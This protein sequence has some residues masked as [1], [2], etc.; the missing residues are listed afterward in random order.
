MTPHR[1]GAASSILVLIDVQERLLGAF[2]EATRDRL[3]PRLGLLLTAARELSIPTVVTEQYPQGLG[4]TLAELRE[5]AGPDVPTLAKTTFSCFGDPAFVPALANARRMPLPATSLEALAEAGTSLILCGI[6]THVCVLQTALDAL[7]AGF[8]RVIVPADAVAA[9][10][11][12]D[13]AVAL[14]LMD[15]EGAWITTAESLVFMLLEDARHPAF[16]PLS[17]RIRQLG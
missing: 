5:A 6:E 12:A 7:A 3:L 13:H 10:H 2:P 9:R 4:P 17:A 16:K 15:R 14:S 1:P 11:E 8:S